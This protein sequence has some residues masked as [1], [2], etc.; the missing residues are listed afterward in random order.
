M[1]AAFTFTFL[2]IWF[3]VGSFFIALCSLFMI[4]LSFPLTQLIF[5]YVFKVMFNSPTN[6]VAIFIVFGIAADNIFIFCDAYK[7]GANYP[8]MVKNE[9][10]RLAYA[11]RRA[12]M[13]ILVTASTTSV[14]FLANMFSELVPTQSFGIYAAT[15]IPINYVL[16]LIMTPPAQI[17]YER[18]FKHRCL[19]CKR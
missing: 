18:Y 6:Q 10:R 14:A 16:M 8:L 17:I 4:L 11:W 2:Y 13:S 5:T 9:K 19:W 7:Q 1:A 3:H 15:V 12:Q